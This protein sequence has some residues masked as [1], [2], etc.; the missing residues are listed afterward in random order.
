[1]KH[2][3]EDKLEMEERLK[4]ICGL[5]N[6][7]L[8]FSEAKNGALVVAVCAV[9]VV[10]A[11]HSPSSADSMWIRLSCFLG[12]AFLVLSGGVSLASFIPQLTFK[13]SETEKE[14]V[15][16][17]N[18]MYFDHIAAFSAFELLEALYQAEGQPQQQRKIEADLAGQAVVNANIASRKFSQF[19]VASWLALIGF[20]CLGVSACVKFWS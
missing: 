19:K 9:V 5:V 14:R 3:T 4:Y 2:S 8:K 11:D 6:D 7:W 16:T 18:L 15:A 10:V 13:W 17:H 12:C 20:A 1:M